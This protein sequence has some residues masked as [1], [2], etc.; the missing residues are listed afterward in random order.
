MQLKFEKF[1]FL[2][3]EPKLKLLITFCEIPPL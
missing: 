1:F 3:S 2:R